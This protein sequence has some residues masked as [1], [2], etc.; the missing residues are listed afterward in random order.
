MGRC[1]G[2]TGERKRT[3]MLYPKNEKAYDLELTTNC[4]SNTEENVT[5]ITYGVRL[6]LHN[7]IEVFHYKDVSF[8]RGYLRR[9]LDLILKSAVP[10]YQIEDLIE[11]YLLY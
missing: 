3:L 5:Y 7:G 10:Y 4:I 1:P 9:Y 6:R 11:D 2:M 8:Y